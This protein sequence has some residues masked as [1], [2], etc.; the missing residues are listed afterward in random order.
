MLYGIGLVIIVFLFFISIFGLLSILVAFIVDSFSQHDNFYLQKSNDLLIKNIM[1]FF[2]PFFGIIFIFG[3]CLFVSGKSSN[4]LIAVTTVGLATSGWLFTNYISSRNSIR[5][6][7]VT[8]LTQLRM[9][10]EFMKNANNLQGYLESRTLITKELL[11]NLN[12]QKK[13]EI[14][15]KDSVRYILN[16]LEFVSAGIRNGDL[17]ELLIK[18]AQRG[19]F[20]QTY[21]LCQ[22]FIDEINKEQET[23]FEH[24]KIIVKR[25]LES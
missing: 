9:S 19:M 21:R 5:Q 2:F 8:V 14:F 4:F 18:S 3:I 16:Y 6:H 17:D 11:D 15:L 23:A 20:L 1:S 24:Y 25:W 13:N 22:P 12:D 7:T 10:T